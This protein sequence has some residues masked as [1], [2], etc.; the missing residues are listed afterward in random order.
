MHNLIVAPS[1]Y[2]FNLLFSH[3]FTNQFHLPSAWPL[4]YALWF[5]NFPIRKLYSHYTV[6]LLFLQIPNQK[7][8]VFRCFYT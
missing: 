6:L 4:C 7:K 1:F 5:H 2:S 3:P 8:T